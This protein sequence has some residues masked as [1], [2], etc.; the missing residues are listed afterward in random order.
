[1]CTI[2]WMQSRL[3]WIQ[4]K[5]NSGINFKIQ[6]WLLFTLS[7]IRVRQWLRIYDYRYLTKPF[8]WL[9]AAIY[10]CTVSSQALFAIGHAIAVPTRQWM[11]LVCFFCSS[12]L[13]YMYLLKCNQCNRIVS[14]CV[15]WN[16]LSSGFF[17]PAQPV[18][19]MW[20]GL[21]TQIFRCCIM[22]WQKF[23]FSRGK[24]WSKY[25]LCDVCC[26]R[27]FFAVPLCSDRNFGFLRGKM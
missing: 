25:M 26:W 12:L 3:C 24:M 17:L 11:K 6:F 10:V 16:F 8:C 2:A 19:C 9:C 5:N 14:K 23:W 7:I 4:S 18:V 27:R 20:L 13:V 15:T 1:M 22:L 21:L